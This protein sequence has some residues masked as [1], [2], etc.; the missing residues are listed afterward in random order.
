PQRRPRGV[1]RRRGAPGRR[2]LRRPLGEEPGRPRDAAAEG[3]PG[4]RRAQA[5]A[6]G[7]ELPGDLRGAEEDHDRRHQ[8]HPPREEE[9][10]LRDRG[11]DPR[12]LRRQRG[13]GGGLE[14]PSVSHVTAERPWLT[15]LRELYAAPSPEE[16]R[17]QNEAY[18]R[19]LVDLG[20]ATREQID[21]CLTR[22]ADPAKPFPR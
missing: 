18:G 15:L 10:A 5:P 11:T 1:R 13:R 4:R 7:Q 2:R 19:L 16:S 9:A 21:R 12:V 3:R 14:P 6:R 17:R 22:P 8:L 20:L